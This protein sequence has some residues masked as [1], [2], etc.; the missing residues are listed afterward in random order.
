MLTLDV[1]DLE[2]RLPDGRCLFE[3][4]KFSLPIDK[5]SPSIMA[6]RGPSGSGKSTLLKC[7]AALIEYEGSITLGGKTANDLSTP[8]W[9]SR[10]AYVPQRPPSIPGTPKQFWELS[11][12]FASIAKRASSLSR[13]PV[14]IAETWGVSQNTWEKEW[15]Q[16]SGGEVQRVVL[17]IAVSREPDVLLL[18]E[19][20]SALDLDSCLQVEE[21]LKRFNCIWITHSSE[22]EERTATTTLSLGN[23]VDHLIV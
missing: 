20:T 2:V 21:T 13:S 7:L 17:A 4:L 8:E 9:R 12:N 10:V 22:Q 18:D 6:I 11:R 23:H 3:N 5:A 19:P 1:K 14:Q 16:L 15:S